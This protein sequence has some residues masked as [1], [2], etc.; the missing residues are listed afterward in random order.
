ME[1]YAEEN[2]W[3]GGNRA[4]TA[5]VS[6][7]GLSIKT[8]Q[9]S[10]LSI[11]GL[12]IEKGKRYIVIGLSGA[13][14]STLL[15]CI[16]S[17]QSFSSGE[18]T[19]FGEKLAKQNNYA[20]RQKMVYVAQHEVLFCGTVE[21]NIGLGLKFRGIRKDLR[22]EKIK[23][24][25]NLVGLAGYEKRNVESLS[26]GEIQ[27]VALARGLV[28]EPEL[29]LLDEPTA[30]LDPYNVQMMEQ[31]ITEYCVNKGATLI[32]ATHNINQAK[33]IGQEGLFIANGELTEMGQVPCILENPES[34]QLKQFLEW[35]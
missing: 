24:V 9:K 23:E 3:P 25:L 8:A 30:N 7:K 34:Q 10:L 32:L 33:R 6:L 19:L 21:Y 13:G 1:V 14:K 17:L 11:G 27:R 12:D 28:T 4:M 5:I 26:G 22:L 31:A 20:L 16:A 35:A 2:A 18:I 15:K 29:L